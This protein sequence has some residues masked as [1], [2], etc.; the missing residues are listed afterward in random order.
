M[1]DSTLTRR[2]NKQDRPADII[3]WGATGF[4]GQLT[5][6]YLVKN[7]PQNVR[8]A[9]AGRSKGK[10]ETVYKK[11]AEF[12]P[13]R[14]IQTFIADSDDSAS[15]DAMTAQGRVL[16]STVGPYLKYGYKL[17]A[18]CVKNQT[19]YVDLTGEPPF[20]RKIIDDFHEE[21]KAN[22]TFIVPSCGFDSI[23]SDLGSFLVADHFAKQGKKT[24]EVRMTVAS[25]K[26]SASGG[27]ISSLLNVVELPMKEKAK[28]R[29]PYYLVTNEVSKGTDRGMSPLMSYDKD[30]KKWQTYFVMES[31][32]SRNVR[33]SN[34]LL[35]NGYG[36]DFKYQETMSVPN[37]FVAFFVAFFTMLAGGWLAFPPTRY[38]TRWAVDK[39]F[40]SGSGPNKEARENGYFKCK[41]VGESETQGP[42]EVPSKAIATVT[43]VQDPG[44]GETSKML[45]ESAL[46]LALDRDRFTNPNAAGSFAGR[47]TGGVVTPA[48]A[49]GNVLVDR[50]RA[51]GM[52]F[53]VKDLLTIKEQ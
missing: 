43:G 3:V 42:N 9:I 27:T 8:I 19:D 10:L 14:K 11:L 13:G 40:P 20:I 26:G 53:E 32:N 51:A 35:K 52:G 24:A 28:L 4:T 15:L 16:I 47:V 6:E 7:A 46:C 21:A 23:P 45:S 36:T 37:V 39:W 31:V 29:D 17:V 18:S 25:L 38:I 2:A 41:L 12:A 30:L 34:A 50:L 33:R 5:A 44:Y 48:S 49:M 22:G 1:T